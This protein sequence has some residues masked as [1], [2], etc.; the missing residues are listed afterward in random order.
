MNKNKEYHVKINP[1]EV[2]RYLGF[3]GGSGQAA[4]QDPFSGVDSAVAH[5]LRRGISAVEA[6]SAPKYTYKIFSLERT[7]GKLFFAGTSAEIQGKDGQ[8]L[9]SDCEEC[10]VLAATLGQKSEMLLRRAQITGM[11]DAVILDSCAS[12]AI[13][14]ICEQLSQDLEAEYESRGLFLTDRFSPGY[15]DMPLT[16]QKELCALLQ[17]EKRIGL[18]VSPGLTLIPSKS[19]TAI[20]GI[21][22][23]P[24]TMRDAA[25]DGCRLRETCAIR[26]AGGCCGNRK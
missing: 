18:T 6:A 14:S 11:S 17:T 3:R 21:S 26:K 20:I 1:F 22:H 8:D 16:M 25:C 9:L 7:D 13:E 23:R 4:D 24:Q 5:Q 19:V 10:I 2:L 12:S 15:G